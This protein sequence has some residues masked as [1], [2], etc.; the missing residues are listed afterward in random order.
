M[1]D[2]IGQAC[3]AAA[4]LHADETGARVAKKL[5]CLHVLATGTLTWLGCHPKRGGEA[6]E[7]FRLLEQFQS[8]LVH[9]GWIPYKALDCQDALC[10]AYHM[11][12]LTY[13]FE[14]QGQG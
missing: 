8:I 2:A 3:A 11:R 5:H 7:A 6:F 10:N 4:A 1:I 12:E 13:L 9:D 14:E